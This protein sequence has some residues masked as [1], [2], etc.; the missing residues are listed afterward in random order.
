MPA[1]KK[2]SRV[3]T[4]LDRRAVITL[5][6]RPEHLH[7]EALDGGVLLEEV[8][9]PSLREARRARTLGLLVD[10]DIARLAAGR[11]RR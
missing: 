7:R 9:Q 10:F 3:S 11:L 5:E 6:Q 8:K 2:A 1:A 4:R